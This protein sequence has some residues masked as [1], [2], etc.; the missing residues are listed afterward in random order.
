[1]STSEKLLKKTCRDFSERKNTP[2]KNEL[3]K[4]N[5]CVHLQ[6]KVLCAVV[7]WKCSSRAFKEVQTLLTV[8]SRQLSGIL[9]LKAD[10]AAAQNHA[11]IRSTPNYVSTYTYISPQCSYS[12]HTNWHT[13]TNRPTTCHVRPSQS[14]HSSQPT[15]LWPSLL[16]HVDGHSPAPS[17]PTINPP[18]PHRQSIFASAHLASQSKLIASSRC[19]LISSL[20]AGGTAAHQVW[21]SWPS[22]SL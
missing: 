16:C 14:Q 13:A 1:M 20:L 6:N 12:P 7:L 3:G 21:L 10:P 17:W 2:G 15:A 19:W 4:V 18:V 11:A 5:L 22:E 8:T 9:H